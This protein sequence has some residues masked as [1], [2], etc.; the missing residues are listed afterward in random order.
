MFLEGSFLKPLED[1][2]I[3]N[4]NF[5]GCSVEEC[6]GIK[7]DCVVSQEPFFS[8][9]YNVVKRDGDKVTYL[10]DYEPVW[11]AEEGTDLRAVIDN[12]IAVGKVKNYS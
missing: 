7:Y 8:G 4:V 1:N 3:W 2:E 11:Q 5:P 10:I 9:G 12:Y 6:K